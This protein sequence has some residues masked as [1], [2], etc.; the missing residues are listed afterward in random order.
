MIHL[1]SRIVQ[2]PD[3]SEIAVYND[4]KS[5]KKKKYFV[6]SDLSALGI[7]GYIHILQNQLMLSELGKS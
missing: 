3:Y 7:F 5:K 2:C 6:D 1:G 4:A